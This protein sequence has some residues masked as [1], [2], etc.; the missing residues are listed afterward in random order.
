[1]PAQ[2]LIGD[3]NELFA[4][5][6][7]RARETNPLVG[8]N[9]LEADATKVLSD[10]RRTAGGRDV[11]FVARA[12]ALVNEIEPFVIRRVNRIHES[13]TRR[14]GHVVDRDDAVAGSNA[15]NRCRRS[16]QY[17][18]DH[19]LR[20]VAGHAERQRSDQKDQIAEQ[21]V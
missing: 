4:A 1:M 6:S 8:W 13:L 14:D 7:H 10:L 5:L 17:F 21:K 18:A 3:R 9:R 12:V 16:R 20:L 19:R 11:D 15:G 2:R